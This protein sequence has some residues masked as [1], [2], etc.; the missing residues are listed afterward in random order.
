MASNPKDTNIF[1]L[2]MLQQVIDYIEES[3]FEKLT[4]SVIAAHFYM[5]ES[6]LSS[7]FRL[8][9]EM[10]MMEYIRNRRLTLAAEEL[11][12]SNIP[13]IELAYKYGYET[14]EAFTK[15]FSR[16]HGFPP[17]FVRRGFP[18]SNIFLPLK[19]EVV[20]HGGWNAMELTKTNC[21]R[22]DHAYAM[23]YNT[24]IANYEGRYKDKH[25]CKYQ[26]DTNRMQFQKEWRILYALVQELSKNHIAFKI[27][28]KTM[29]FAHGLEIPLDKICLTFKWKDEEEV[30][31][32]FH[33][34]RLSSR[35]EENI[36]ITIETKHT[37]ERFKYFDVM[38]EEMK[39]RCMFYGNCIGDDTDEFLYKNTDFISIN[40]LIVPVQSL[41][42]YCENTEKNSVYY[43][44]VEEWLGRHERL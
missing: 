31:K 13:I 35:I 28:G 32:F 16:F 15:A 33:S 44:M 42:F 27:D 7:L 2:P 41:E 17:S 38:Y 11:S 3:I 1:S 5:S 12:V 25:K 18:V 37:G 20:I 10:T 43:K 34:D 39:I 4:P 19:I 21:T 6:T 36:E 23:N 9:C 8:V 24:V 22:Q 26:I 29:I 30:K 14:P 40:D